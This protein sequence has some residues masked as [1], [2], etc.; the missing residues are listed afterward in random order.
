[1]HIIF[2]ML[3]VVFCM[4]YFWIKSKNGRI[5]KKTNKFYKTFFENQKMDKNKCPFFKF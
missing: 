1:M 5:S 3:Y 2:C 4:L